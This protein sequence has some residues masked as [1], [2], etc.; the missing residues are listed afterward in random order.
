MTS[1]PAE[2]QSSA[3]TSNAPVSR[4]RQFLRHDQLNVSRLVSSNLITAKSLLV[5]RLIITLHL[6]AVFIATL[7]VSAR[8]K[9]FYMVPT[10][11]TNLSNIGLTAYYLAATYHS[12]CYVRNKNLDSLTKQHWFLTTALWMLYASVVVYHIVVP[13]IYWGLLFDPNNTMDPLNEYVDYS[14]HGIDF[15]CI[16]SEMVFNHMNLLFVHV[17]GPISMIILYMFLAWVYYAARKEWLYGFLDWS[18]SLAPAWY[19]GLLL[20]FGLLF[21]LQLYIHRGRDA[22]FRS[23]RYKVGAEDGTLALESSGNDPETKEHEK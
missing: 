15:F 10:T 8:D 6:V 16:L 14:H 21:L 11:F 19:I 20:I 7:Y 1:V 13:A 22:L 2:T 12:H 9:V 23:R 5:V 18:S 17:L 4:L 3:P